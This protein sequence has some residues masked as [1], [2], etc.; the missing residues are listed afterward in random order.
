MVPTQQLLPLKNQQVQIPKDQICQDHQHQLRE[1]KN[2]SREAKEFN[3]QLTSH[4]RSRAHA[5]LTQA[6]HTANQ[7]QQNQALAQQTQQAH[8]T[9]AQHTASQTRSG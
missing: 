7:A 1:P 9:Q 8:Y 3:Y 4:S 6:Q 5:P 2:I